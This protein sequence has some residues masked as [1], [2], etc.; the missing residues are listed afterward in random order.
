MKPYT[1]NAYKIEFFSLLF[2]L[3]PLVA[4]SFQAGRNSPSPRGSQPSLSISLL[5]QQQQ[6]QQNENL[7]TSS[8]SSSRLSTPSDFDEIN[9][10]PSD[11]FSEGH[12]LAK[13]FYKQV[14]IREEKSELKMKNENRQVTQK[15]DQTA[16]TSRIKKFTGRKI[17]ELD[18][19]GMPSAGLFTNRNGSVFAIANPGSSPISQRNVIGGSLVEM[20]T[21]RD[22]MMRSEFD[23][24]RI[25]SNEN[26]LA[27]QGILVLAFLCFAIYIGFTGGITDGSERFGLEPNEFNGL[28]MESFDFSDKVTDIPPE[29]LNGWEEQK[30]NVG[31]SIWL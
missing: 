28:G 8:S 5:Q 12:Y 3:I 10:N 21:P 11:D 9:T 6:H 2:I 27:I 1:I 22:R 26:T 24:M 7:S 19:S 20:E 16:D 18:S 25:A 13:E 23:L 29:V 15:N 31:D 17:G 4:N 30:R 14:K